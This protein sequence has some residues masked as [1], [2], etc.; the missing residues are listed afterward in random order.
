[1]NKL[2]T[3]IIGPNWR[4]T[5]AGVVS[6]LFMGFLL[7]SVVKPELIYGV[8]GAGAWGKGVVSTCLLVW[9]ISGSAKDF[10]TKDKQ[11]AGNNPDNVVIADV[12]T[13]TAK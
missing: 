7:A 12:Q 4:T 8:F 5:I 3:D 11:V 1:M 9:F 6:R 2:L 10:N 13:K